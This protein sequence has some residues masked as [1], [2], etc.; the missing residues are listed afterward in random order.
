[1]LYAF[2]LIPGYALDSLLSGLSPVQ[3]TH[4]QRR[5]T[6]QHSGPTQS[7]GKAP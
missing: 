1:M 7:Q 6:H 2:E 4:Q 5:F 3:M